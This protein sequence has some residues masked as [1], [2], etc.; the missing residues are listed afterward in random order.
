MMSKYKTNYYLSNLIVKLLYMREKEGIGSY[1]LAEVLTKPQKIK[2]ICKND[3]EEKYIS[4]LNL[5]EKYNP[6]RSHFYVT[7]KQL[8]DDKI[9]IRKEDK[10]R[11]NQ[12]H[13]KYFLS[14]I[15]LLCIR[16]DYDPMEISKIVKIS[17]LIFTF[18]LRGIDKVRS[19]RLDEKER[20]KKVVWVA[21][22]SLINWTEKKSIL[23]YPHPIEHSRGV[24]VK[25]LFE[26]QYRY[27]SES[28]KRINISE[29]EIR[30]LILYMQEKRILR[31]IYENGEERYLLFDEQIEEF[32]QQVLHLFGDIEQKLEVKIGY[33]AQK[34]I[35][36]IEKHWCEI[37]FNKESFL[38]LLSLGQNVKVGKTWKEK[39]SKQTLTCD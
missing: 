25:E 38:E 24:S 14:E 10:T 34:R 31:P 37:H 29:E 8:L 20:I 5:R 7:I 26:T 3:R 18:A 22:R 15:G 19:K 11:T 12:K 36:K 6:S 17:H 28:S 35:E 1:L 21:E 9:I 33:L 27:I 2:K 23:L 4:E 39:E 13:V 32:L 30:I 16:F